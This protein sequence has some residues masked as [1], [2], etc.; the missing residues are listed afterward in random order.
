MIF[1]VLFKKRDRE[2][3]GL[4]HKHTETEMKTQTCKQINETTFRQELVQTHITHKKNSRQR[5]K[6]KEF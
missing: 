2:G 3:F 4:G 6:S 1:S 5:E